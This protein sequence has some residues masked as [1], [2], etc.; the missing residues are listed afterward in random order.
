MQ[1]SAVSTAEILGWFAA[2]KLDLAS[3]STVR[4]L[5]N[6]AY[7]APF[8]RHFFRQFEQAGGRTGASCTFSSSQA[9][10]W[11]EVLACLEKDKAPGI[12]ILA[13]A[14]DMVSLAQATA[15]SGKNPVL[16]SSGWGATRELLTQGGRF[17]EGIYVGK[18]G[19]FQKPESGHAAFKQRYQ[20]RFG[21]IPCFAAEQGY[22][23]IQVLARALRQT[24]GNPGG[25][26]D[27][28]AGITDFPSFYGP[29]SLDQYGDAH[30]PTHILQI[31]D[32]RF[33]HR[34]TV[35]PRNDDSK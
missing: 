22:H 32:G 13:S 3:V 2:Q 20:N 1:P 16:L 33:E 10:N 34:W 29:L 27:A 23:A 25:L 31:Q 12:L 7:T 21:R 28:L 15:A 14:M 6:D 11:S 17:V 35:E 8:Q 18:T 9:G 26:P 19:F 4:D 24:G 30:L 5:A